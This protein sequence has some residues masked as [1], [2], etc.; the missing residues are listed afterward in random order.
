MGK[1]GGWKANFSKNFPQKIATRLAE[2]LEILGARYTPVAFLG[3][4]S[5]NGTNDA[6]LAEQIAMNGFDTKAAV[7]MVF[8][9]KPN[10]NDIAFLGARP[11]AEEG[12]KLGGTE[13]HVTTDIPNEA[14]EAFNEAISG[15]TGAVITPVAYL[16]KQLVH[17]TNFDMIAEVKK[18]T[19][20]E[21]SKLAFITVNSFYNTIKFAD[22]F[23]LGDDETPEFNGAKIENG[24]LG[25]AF[26]WLTKK[27]N[28]PLGE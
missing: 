19:A 22:L 4:Q 1:F 6:V 5:I 26:T 28:S 10:S 14:K 15:Y 18:D 2:P 8:N 24:K 13:I 12:G 21:A 7:I 27:I 23:E 20:S 3:T 25:Y 9:E 11:L 16:G 17:G